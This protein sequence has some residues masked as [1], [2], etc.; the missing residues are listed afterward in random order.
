MPG[1]STVRLQDWKR[2]LRA[3][4]GRPPARPRA[5]WTAASVLHNGCPLGNLIP[6]WNDLV[7]R[8]PG[9]AAIDRL[10]ATNNFPSSP[11]ASARPR[12]RPRASSASTR[13]RSPSSRSRSRSSTALGRGLGHPQPPKPRSPASTVAVVGSGPPACRRPAAHRA[14]HAVAVFERA[15]RIGGLLRYGIPEFKMEKRHLDRR[16]GQMEAEGV[17]SAPASTSATD[18]TGDDL[19]RRSTPSCCHRGATQPATSR[20]G[21]E[22]A[23]VHQAME[24]LPGANRVQEGDLEPRPIDAAGKH[25]VVIGG[26]DTG[27]DCL[28]TATARAPPVTQLEIMPM[29]PESRPGNQPWPTYPM[30]FKVTSAHEEGGE[31]WLYRV[32]DQPFIDDGNGRCVPSSSWVRTTPVASCRSRAPSARSPPTS[33]SSR[34]ASP[35]RSAARCSTSSA[36]SSTTAATSTAA[37]T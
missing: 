7:Y 19:R 18:V 28:G 27:A 4:P 21:R 2:G 14:G 8:G 23:G 15:D 30:T 9:A 13:T 5:A 17:S 33:C 36:S 31:V 3:V 25:V 24:Y 35:A 26:G 34:W 6:D 22:L 10:H 16:L 37:T 29:P 11:G 32:S 12:A 20:P 1:P